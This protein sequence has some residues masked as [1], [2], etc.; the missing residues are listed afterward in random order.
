MDEGS[1]RTGLIV[2]GAMHVAL[3][4]VLV[5]GFSHAPRFDDATESIPVETVTT[6]QLN[7]IMEGEKTARPSQAKPAP[8]PAKAEPVPLPPTPPPPAPE[9]PK[10]PPPELPTPA[11]PPEPPTRPEPPKPAPPPPEP[12]T[13]PQPPKPQAENAPEPPT[14]PRPEKPVAA[15]RPPER[16][17][18]TETAAKP[19]KFRPDEIAKALA[20]E[21][22]QAKPRRNAPA[23]D[24]R[25]IA[26]LIGQSKAAEAEPNAA[27]RQG[28]AN[29]HSAQMSVSLENALNEWF[30][31]SYKNC[32]NLPP[33]NPTGE[34]YVFDVR[35][36]F[37]SDGSLA[38]RPVML[39]PPHDPQWQAHADSVMRAVLRCN[40]LHIPAQYAP[41]FDQ[42]RTKIVHFDPSSADG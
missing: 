4:A 10:P 20:R 17:R 36:T 23:Y 42:W 27:Q 2:S 29:R 1:H 31:D 24:P 13:R 12:P 28:L 6:A 38:A 39:N 33:T 5:F 19:D 25:A 15:P 41:Y 9:P 8:A 26:K 37:N 21:K 3:L 14:R 7:Q 22:A 35:V 34:N 32:W 18:R 40:P 11:P 16:P 30:R